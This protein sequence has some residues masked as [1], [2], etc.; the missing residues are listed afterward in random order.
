[1]THL[2]R[3]DV[4]KLAAQTRCA[5]CKT[6]YGR[7]G[8]QIMGRRGEAWMIAVTCPHCNTEGL[9]I[10]TV[11]DADTAAVEVGEQEESRPQIMYD[12]TYEEW[13]AFQELPP[14][15]YDDVL[16]LHLFLKDFD[17]DFSGLFGRDAEDEETAVE[18]NVR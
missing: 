14:L 6:P 17:G 4:A 9:L 12:V 2:G 8:V 15:G 7:E 5:V 1:M 10:A 18:D 3:D 11:D 16:D 13:L